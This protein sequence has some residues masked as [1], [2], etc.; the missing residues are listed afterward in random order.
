MNRHRVFKPTTRRFYYGVGPARRPDY[1]PAPRLMLL[2]GTDLLRNGRKPVNR[3]QF[4][5]QTDADAA[6]VRRHREH[7][8]R[9]AGRFG[10]WERYANEL[11]GAL[12]LLAD[13]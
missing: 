12:A 11:A 3:L 7:Y 2:E 8:E 13:R 6:V 9:P 4:V 5:P 10:T 1:L